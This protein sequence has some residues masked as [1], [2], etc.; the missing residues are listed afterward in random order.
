MNTQSHHKTSCLPDYMF[1]ELTTQT[2]L[3]TDTYTGVNYTIFKH[4]RFS[5]VFLF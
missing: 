2:A 5:P 4:S 1:Q 3:A